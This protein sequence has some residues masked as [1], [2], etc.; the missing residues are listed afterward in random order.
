MPTLHFGPF[1]LDLTDDG[2]W[3]GSQRGH[4]K[5]KAMAVLRYLVEHPGRLVHK[6]EPSAGC[7]P[8]RTSG[9]SPPA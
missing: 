6:I 5:A 3:R 2:L 1:H 4:L 7:A 8:V 9:A